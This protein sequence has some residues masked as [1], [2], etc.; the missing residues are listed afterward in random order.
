M[1]FTRPQSLSK[2]NTP[3]GNR[4]QMNFIDGMLDAGL[5]T[6]PSHTCNG[7]HGRVQVVFLD[8]FQIAS[9]AGLGAYSMSL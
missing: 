3:C 5:R 6:I 8:V 1:T 7:A 4:P 2:A 9:A